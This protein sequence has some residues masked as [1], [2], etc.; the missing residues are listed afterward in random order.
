MATAD[1]SI[2][3]R[4]CQDG[5]ERLW[6]ELAELG[7]DDIRD[8]PADF[9]ELTELQIRVRDAVRTGSR[10]HD[11][12]I[13]AALAQAKFPVHFMDFETFMPALPLFVG[14]RPYQTIPFQWSD[15]VLSESGQVSHSE[16]LHDSQGDPRRRFAESLLDAMGTVGSVVVYSGYEERCLRELEAALPN[17]A[18][19]L[20]RLRARL[21]DLHPVIKTHVYDPR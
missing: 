8:I 19:R 4:S 14:T 15:H 17:L 10:Y 21:F 1:P 11:P 5:T 7:I 2:R 13:V 16:F 12:A 6:A 18:S 20:A 9:E 3:S